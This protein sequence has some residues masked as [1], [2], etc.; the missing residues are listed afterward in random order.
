MPVFFLTGGLTGALACGAR[1]SVLGAIVVT[2]GSGGV[3]GPGPGRGDFERAGR[4]GIV[5][6]EDAGSVD[7]SFV[8]EGRGGM[9]GG[10]VIVA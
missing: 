2:A 1:S 4:G 3:S 9:E 6:A 8:R 5:G 10:E 7:S